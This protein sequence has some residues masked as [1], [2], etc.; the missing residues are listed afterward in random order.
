[1]TTPY[2]TAKQ[3]VEVYGLSVFP[4]AEWAKV[5]AVQGGRN[6]LT[7]DVGKLD[8]FYSKRP[9]CNYGIATG[10]DAGG[11][12]VIDCDV[13]DDKGEDGIAT[14]RAWEAA[15]GELPECPTVTTPRGGMHLYYYSD[16]Q[17]SC[18]TNAELGIDIRG[19]GGYVVGAGSVLRNGSY[20]WDLDIEDYAIPT[21]DDNVL[22]FVAHVQKPKMQKAKFELPKEIG[23]GN[24]N[25]T[26][27]RY[28]C[29]LRANNMTEELIIAALLGTN[30]I[31]CKPPLSEEEILKIVESACKHEAGKSKELKLRESASKML[32]RNNSGAPYK[33]IDNCMVVLNNDS[34]LAGRF[35]YNSHGHLPMVT[36]PLPWD[37]GDGT[38]RMRDVD[39]TQLAAFIE[40]TYG[41]T[42]CKGIAADAIS[43]VCSDNSRNPVREWLES[44]HWDGND[45]ISG[46]LPIFLGA[47]RNEYTSGVMRLFM[48]GACARAVNPGCKFDSMIVLV[49]AQG[50]GKS[51]FLRLLAHNDEWFNDNFNTIHGDTAIEK[52]QGMWILEM[53]ELLATSN[54]N[55]MEAV[56]SFLTSTSDVI[57]PKYG[58]INE[59][60]P[61]A[62]VFAGTTNNA[63]F[64]HDTTGERR[65]L[66]IECKAT[67]A[68]AA[69]FDSEAPAFI[70]QCW[71]QAYFE[72]KNGDGSLVLP[73][74]LLDYADEIRLQY[75]EDDPRV[76][77][78]QE[79]LDKRLD[80]GTEEDSRVC[81]YEIAQM[82]L[83][84]ENYSSLP[85]ATV[86][87]IHEIMR[88]RIDGWKAYDGNK[89]GK[90]RTRFGV[91]R[92]Y[93]RE[94]DANVAE[95]TATNG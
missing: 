15:H 20:E 36:L 13:D 78:I 89:S 5:P 62:C 45:R 86:N 19:D 63:M 27:Y 30:T 83:N 4:L 39:I 44:L 24:R 33:T 3:L 28:A 22:A 65:F 29:S 11:L 41:I 43:N 52:L 88:C 17:I 1:M 85:R 38:R 68:S 64:L 16:R 21:A 61:R 90:A 34:R 75:K 32:S 95:R 18:S 9:Q 51:Y 25:D 53:A 93:V 35:W 8:A 71:A 10:S 55:D 58:R 49:G 92:C 12:F 54:V 80:N 31:R 56:K 94:K 23:K 77:I 82:A 87:E 6:A 69:L 67:K 50:I 7:R 76:G 26:L 72:W 74:E 91:Q 57:R 81:V 14:L 59:Q 46:M 79:Y 66:P 37:N 70:A 47:E 73:D 40:R 48:H 2:D 60:R 42:N 84:I